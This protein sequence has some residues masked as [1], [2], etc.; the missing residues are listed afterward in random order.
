MIRCLRPTAVAVAVAVAAWV[1]P[2][3]DS[4]ADAPRPI[5]VVVSPK[6]TEAWLRRDSSLPIVVLSFRFAGGSALDSPGREGLARFLAAMLEEGAGPY[7]AAAFRERLDDRAIRL[8]LSAGRDSL[9]GTLRTLRE[10]VDE[11]AALLGHALA[12]PRFDD[13]S[14]ARVRRQLDAIR[15]Q[16]EVQ[17][18]S[19][20]RSRWFSLV[21]GDGAYGRTPSGTKASLV[22][23]RADDLRAASS[24]RLV[25]RRLTVGAAGDL[26]PETLA[27]VLD[28]AFGDLALG[29]PADEAPESGRFEGRSLHVPME[30]PQTELVFGLPGLARDDTDFFPAFVLN[31]ILGGS[32]PGSRLES[33]IRRRRGLAYSIYS[34]LTDA[35]R[36]PLLLGAT[37]TRA[38]SAG[39]T[40]A[41]V[42]EVIRRTRVEGPTVAELVD[43]KRYLTGSFPLATDS[44]S[45]IADFL[46]TLQVYDLGIDYLERRNALVEA[47]TITDVRR[48]ARRLLDEEAVVWVAVGRSSPFPPA[49]P[50]SP[51]G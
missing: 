6:G 40:V 30:I 38:E 22:G 41:A 47:V 9:Y 11:A 16:N 14:V 19:L 3:G 18:G 37:S 5:E 34:Y 25:R 36:A 26:D 50:G 23:I 35:A 42:R 15:A 10:N 39:E 13:D 33:E 51:Q 8:S 27:R 46:V 43:A 2:P 28:R 21:F 4:R 7:D 29:T 31:A 20:A 44:T 49:R 45:E 32:A 48:V 17:P 24:Q 12:R 1:T